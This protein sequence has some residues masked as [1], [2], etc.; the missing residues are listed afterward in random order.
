[1]GD[2]G[3][4]KLLSAHDFASTYAAQ[5]GSKPGDYTA[6][7]VLDILLRDGGAIMRRA[8]AQAIA[9]HEGTQGD[10]LEAKEG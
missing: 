2:F 9:E 3:L 8:V 5:T 1:M 10:T 6:R 4:S 7:V